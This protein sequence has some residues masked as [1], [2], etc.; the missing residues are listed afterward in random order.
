MSTVN[1]LASISNGLF[2]S[3]VAGI[4]LFAALKQ[5][6]VYESFV[7]GAKSGFTLV[8]SLIPYLVAMIVAIG[9]LRASGAFEDLSYLLAPLL[10]KIGFPP[11]LL[12]LALMRPFSGS[13]A[14][15]VL[16]EIIHHHGANSMIALMA[17]TVMG[18]TETTFYVLAVYFGSVNIQKTRHAILAGLLA[19]AVGVF[20]SVWI[21]LW[22]FR[23]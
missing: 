12:P 8:V 11:D 22:L 18:S 7:E 17:A 4:P 3:V 14:T 19:D 20:A 2:L 6:K 15:G 23:H 16:A 1:H 13:G 10:S 21:C 9:M 5:V